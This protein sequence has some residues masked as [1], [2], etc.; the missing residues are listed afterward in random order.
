MKDFQGGAHGLYG[1]LSVV[2]IFH[3]LQAGLKGLDLRVLEAISHVFWMKNM[4]FPWYFPSKRGVKQVLDLLGLPG[5]ELSRL[6]ARE[7]R[8]PTAGALPG[9]EAQRGASENG[10]FWAAFGPFSSISLEIYMFF[11]DFIDFH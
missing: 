7:W 6:G 8:V 1:G 11:F 2:Q 10:P 3:M 9:L 4:V 5:H